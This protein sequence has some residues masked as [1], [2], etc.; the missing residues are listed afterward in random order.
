MNCGKRSTSWTDSDSEKQWDLSW[1]HWHQGHIRYDQMLRLLLFFDSRTRLRMVY[2]GAEQT[3]VQIDHK[4]SFYTDALTARCSPDRQVKLK[5]FLPTGL[6]WP[7]WSAYAVLR[8][9][10]NKVVLSVHGL[11]TMI[12]QR[13]AAI[14]KLSVVKNDWDGYLEYTFLIF[15]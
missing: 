8:A 13:K 3:A 5:H 9:R 15:E 1:C 11:A 12:L 4:T 6:T 7:G 2:R 10:W 14:G